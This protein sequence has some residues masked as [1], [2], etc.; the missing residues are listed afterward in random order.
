MTT[1]SV[2]AAMLRDFGSRDT[3]FM[4]IIDEVREALLAQA[5]VDKTTH[6]MVPLPGSGT[7]GLESVFRSVISSKREVLVVSNGA[8]GDRLIRLAQTLGLSNCRLRFPETSP[9]DL[10]SISAMIGNRPTVSHLAFVH[11]ET[12]TGQVN[13]LVAVSRIARSLGLSVIV[14]AMSSFGG[15][16]ID[17]GKLPVDWLITSPNKCLQGV[18]GCALIIGKRSLLADRHEPRSM[19]LN[20]WKYVTSLDT[21]RQY[22]FTPPTH[23]I[24]ALHQALRE[25]EEEGGPFKRYDRY[26]DNA[27]ALFDGMEGLGFRAL[28]SRRNVS[29]IISSFYYP[30]SPLFSFTGF[31]EAL[32]TRGFVIYPGKVTALPSFRI[33]TIGELR[34][35]D[36]YD[37]LIAVAEV[38]REQGL[39]VPLTS[40]RV[41][42]SE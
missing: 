12:S 16:P 21:E 34:R 39:P 19:A 37:L 29:P 27:V 6:F 17:L 40:P 2:K 30:A 4:Q 8:Y 38:L 35:T 32:R 20:L 3:P 26:M 22:P 9:F 14:D 11:C 1:P 5:G 28:F 23:V 15:I 7:F 31:A 13:N 18:P 24:L 36:I 42:I 41:P 25:L 10:L 33:G